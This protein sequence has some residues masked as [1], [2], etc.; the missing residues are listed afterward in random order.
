MMI[1][2]ERLE[3]I[4]LVKYEDGSFECFSATDPDGVR[5]TFDDGSAN[6]TD[7]TK[8][9]SILDDYFDKAA[10]EEKTND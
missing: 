7:A 9:R 2:L 10:R 8:F 6:W 3:T 5:D 1:D 4:T